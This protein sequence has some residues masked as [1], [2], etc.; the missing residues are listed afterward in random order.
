ME[1]TSSELQN[2]TGIEQDTNSNQT[3]TEVNENDKNIEESTQEEPVVEPHGQ[4]N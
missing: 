2:Q 1:D 3:S 4:L